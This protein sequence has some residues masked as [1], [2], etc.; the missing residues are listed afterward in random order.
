MID[1]GTSSS[2]P[3]SHKD[4]TPDFQ[5]AEDTTPVNQTAPRAAAMVRH[6]PS[7]T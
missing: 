1:Q 2:S 7:L 3:K 4:S 6:P 5:D